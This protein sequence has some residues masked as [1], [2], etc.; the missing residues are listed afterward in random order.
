M[1][2]PDKESD[3]NEPDKC[4]KCGVWLEM[5]FGLAGGGYGPYTYCPKHGIIEK[6]QEDAE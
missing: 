3:L 4:P 5:G 6:F 1:K 2:E